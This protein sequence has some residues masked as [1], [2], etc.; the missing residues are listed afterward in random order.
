MSSKI[1]IIEYYPN[2][3]INCN[4]NDLQKSVI[5]LFILKVLFTK[6]IPRLV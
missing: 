2:Y 4:N 1:Y 5:K 6:A 3:Q